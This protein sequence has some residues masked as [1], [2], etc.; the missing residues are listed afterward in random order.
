MLRL[1]SVRF[2]LSCSSFLNEQT[3]RAHTSLGWKVTY[4]VGLMGIYV[5]IKLK[6]YLK[7]IF[8]SGQERETVK[9]KRYS[10]KL[11]QASDFELHM[12]FE[13]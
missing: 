9:K 5:E 4:T 8:L 11:V 3:K 1:L 2:L 10:G 12:L 7:L 6:N 13:Y